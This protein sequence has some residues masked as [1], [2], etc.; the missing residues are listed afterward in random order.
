M[1]WAIAELR[2]G[3]TFKCALVD[4]GGGRHAVFACPNP[5]FFGS[6]ALPTCDEIMKAIAEEA[7]PAKKVKLLVR[8]GVAEATSEWSHFF[9][10]KGVPSLFDLSRAGADLS[11]MS[12]E[13][14]HVHRLYSYTRLRVHGGE[15]STGLTEEEASNLP[16]LDFTTPGHVM[17]LCIQGRDI[18]VAAHF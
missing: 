10:E 12:E 17:C 7:E 4:I 13:D 18:V 16:Q 15:N 9:A 14:L 1:L 3:Q 6:N 8:E 5:S 11:G 2:P